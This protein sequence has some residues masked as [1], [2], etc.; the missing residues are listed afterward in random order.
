[1]KMILR[2]PPFAENELLFV[3]GT[4]LS[5]LSNH[6]HMQGASCLGPAVIQGALFDLGDYPALLVAGQL[7][8][9]LGPVHGELY[10]IDAAHWH[11]LDV[12][13][14]LDPE[15]IENSMYLR[16][17]AEV[18]WLASERSQALHAQVY[19]YNWSLEGRRRI[20]NG[21]FRRHVSDKKT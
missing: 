20:E 2:K 10:K 17:T 21:D 6:H 8:E 12:L 3:Y 11:H 19:V 14:E 4:L 15:S 18:M 13:E 1:M 5:G 7:A 9:P 16:K